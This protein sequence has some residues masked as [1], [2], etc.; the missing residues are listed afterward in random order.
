MD[1][2][3]Y[4]DE[5]D[6]ENNDDMEIIDFNESD[7]VYITVATELGI[8]ENIKVAEN[9]IEMLEVAMMTESYKRANDDSVFDFYLN[10]LSRDEKRLRVLGFMALMDV[11]EKKELKRRL[12]NIDKAKKNKRKILKKSKRKNRKK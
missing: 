4:M 7:P 9:K 12:K 1:F 3:D 6:F 5:Y 10:H 2:K 11:F 8:I